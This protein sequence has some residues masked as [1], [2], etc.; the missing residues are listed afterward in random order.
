MIRGALLI[1]AAL[2]ALASCTK[3][4]T[5]AQRVTAAQ[6][7]EI[8]AGEAD[9][10]AA[11]ATPV[12]IAEVVRTDLS[13]EVSAPGRT[14][15]IAV[16]QVRAPFAGTLRALL[17]VDGDRVRAGQ[18]VARMVSQN[19]QAAL[20]GAQAMLRAAR[21]PQQR[22]DAERALVLAQRGLVEL[23]L[24]APEAGV[25]VSHGYS[26][27]SLLAANDVIA[28]IATIGSFVFI[29]EL[30]QDDLPRIHP[31]Q[32]ASITLA[33]RPAP[34]DGV[35]HG[36]IP[37]ASA[38]NLTVPVRI[39]FRGGAFVPTAIDLFGTARITVGE[40]RDVLAV[41]T[42]AVLRDDISGI[43]RV[44]VVQAGRA[45]WVEVHTGVTQRGLMELRSPSLPAGEHVITMG[46][47]GLPE[48]ARVHAEP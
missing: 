21:T 40:H 8:D 15:A 10:A 48:G 6:E 47:V 36:I 19:S 34:L 7:A 28:T 39:D 46:Q 45:H 42:A 31:G 20:E 33:A 26:A 12:K 30:V 29:A 13:V 35:V 16:Q 38:A 1:A 44:A 2:L 24:R 5:T 37:A 18:V 14:A 32:H 4:P 17:V 23:A 22:S 3:Q 11:P 9:D 25:V 43:E 27:G 41:P